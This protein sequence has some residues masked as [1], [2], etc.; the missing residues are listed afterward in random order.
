MSFIGTDVSNF[1]LIEKN[2][3]GRGVMV[4]AIGHVNIEVGRNG[5]TSSNV[6]MEFVI[7]RGQIVVVGLNMHRRKQPS[8]SCSSLSSSSS[9]SSSLLDFY[10]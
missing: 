8:S 5:I 1:R 4:K 9:P 3:V 7:H 2:R 6:V 10:T